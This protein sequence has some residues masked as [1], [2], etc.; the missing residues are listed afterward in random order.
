MD[1]IFSVR[2][3]I[4]PNIGSQTLSPA[5]EGGAYS[6][7]I[8]IGFALSEPG[9][10]TVDGMPEW[11]SFEVTPA[12]PGIVPLPLPPLG[13]SSEI[14]FTGTPS[15]DDAGTSLLTITVTDSNGNFVSEDRTLTVN[16]TNR[17]PQADED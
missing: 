6:D 14:L 15:F 4:P 11:L 5:S 13:Y 3:P 8:G 9:P 17:A 2:G 10:I 12:V 16:S 7:S 1:A